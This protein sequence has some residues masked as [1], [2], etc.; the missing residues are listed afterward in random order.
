L[1]LA[2]GT[3]RDRNP[4]NRIASALPRLPRRTEREGLACP[5]LADDN[6]DTVAAIDRGCEQ[7]WSQLAQR[8][9]R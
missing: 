1:E 6:G 8:P 3:A 5:S 9:P 4:E 2:S 7:T